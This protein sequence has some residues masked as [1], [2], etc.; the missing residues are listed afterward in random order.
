[1]RYARAR[2]ILPADLINKLQ[3]YVDGV[4]LYIPRRQETR[5]SWGEK[6]HSKRETAQRNE[7]IY[8]AHQTGATVQD[9][10]RDYFLTEK[11]IR[12]ILLSQRR[13]ME[14]NGKA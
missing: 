11:T 10:A 4:Y 5:L 2:D 9:L 13:A 12:R 7:E 8:K 1:M 3:E 14:E 6:T